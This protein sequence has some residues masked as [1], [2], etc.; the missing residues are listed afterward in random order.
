MDTDI[1]TENQV[2]E[3]T[4]V[5]E[6][7]AQ[8]AKLLSQE[9][10]NRIVAERVERERKKFEKKYEGVD[11]DRYRSLAEA[12]E[13]RKLEEQKR[14]GEF[15]S[16]LK[17]TVGKKDAAITQLKQELESIKV[18]GN[19]LNAASSARAVNPQQVV[20]LLKNQVRLGESGDVEIL[21][22][23]SNTVRYNDRGEPMSVPELVTEF[24]TAN[25]HFVAATPAGA[26]TTSNT[27]TQG[28]RKLDV[29]QLDMKNPEH[30]RLYAE[31]RKSHGIA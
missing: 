10:V 29:S 24:L 14:R 6:S 17:E 5:S 31:H 22:P 26:G 8:E 25:P 11:L 28:V 19:M 27:R 15:E 18:D 20:A 13:A 2:A 30:R 16:I 3:T 4:G 1:Q 12:E 9:E 21:D 23:K 7:Q